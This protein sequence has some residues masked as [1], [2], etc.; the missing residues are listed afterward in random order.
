MREA[1]AAAGLRFAAEAFVDRAYDARGR[2][3]PRSQAGAVIAEPAAAAATALRLARDRAVIAVDGREIA[4][5]A[6]T[7]CLHGDT[8]RAVDVARAVR[9]ALAGAGVSV[10][11]LA[12]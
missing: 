1:A 7:L 3:V 11:A 5:E 2:L 6:D 4:V 9:A 12:R 8:P 10:Q